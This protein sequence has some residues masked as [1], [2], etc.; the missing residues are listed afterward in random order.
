[1]EQ[2][3]HDRNTEI[4]ALKSRLTSELN[5]LESVDVI[6]TPPPKVSFHHECNKHINENA[7]LD[8]IANILGY[9][10]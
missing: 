8:S 9:P 6:G 7:L 10:Y 5:D 1:M 4:S 2:I 3:L